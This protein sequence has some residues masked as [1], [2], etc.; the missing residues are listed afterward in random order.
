MS[1]L[2]LGLGLEEGRLEKEVGGLEE[3]LL[4][5]KIKYYP[6]CPQQELALGVEAHTDVCALTFIL[7]NMVP[8][9]QHFY[10][11]K[12]VRA[13]CVPDST[14]MQVG[15]TIEILS[16]GKYKSI[17]HRGLVNKEKVGFHGLSS[18]SRLGKI[19]SSNLFLRLSP[20]L[21]HH[22]SLLAPFNSMFRTKSS[23]R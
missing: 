5:M 11:G 16:I 15:D 13:K 14:I 1:I 4:K 18:V 8:G 7:H 21:S 10:R 23:G 9:L 12:W 2:S 3:L 17:I 19:P 20:R 22:C 6:K